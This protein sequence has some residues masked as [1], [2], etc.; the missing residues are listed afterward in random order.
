MPVPTLITDLSTVVASNSPAGSESPATTDDYFRAHAAFIAQM[1]A[2]I[3][4]SVNP[5]IPTNITTS[6]TDTTAGRV[7]KVGDFGVNGGAAIEVLSGSC[8][9]LTINGA[10]YSVAFA[11]VSGGPPLW[12]SAGQGFLE[13]MVRPDGALTQ[14]VLPAAAAASAQGAFMR[15][16]SSGGV[17]S[18]WVT[19]QQDSGWL[20]PSLVNSFTA[21][22]L[23][24]PQYRRLNN[25]VYIRGRVDRTSIPANGLTIFTLPAGYRANG[26]THCVGTCNLAD[27]AGN[28]A[29]VSITTDLNGLVS[30][31]VRMNAGYPSTLVAGACFIDLNATISLLG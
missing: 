20:S 27:G 11:T 13:V 24:A 15:S 16:R 29:P 2:V 9:S 26:L 23:I 6:A 14:I 30:V 1:R 31:G 28:A 5:D 3:G 7:T 8:D 22:G 10:V 4:G 17:W 25:V 18:D 21:N 19:I 12:V